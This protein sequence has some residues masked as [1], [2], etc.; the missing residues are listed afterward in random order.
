MSVINVVLK[1]T[2]PFST[3]CKSNVVS[4]ISL[5]RS[6]WLLIK[7]KLDRVS[8]PT[9]CFSCEITS[10]IATAP[11]LSTSAACLDAPFNVSSPT[12]C[13][14]ELITSLIAISAA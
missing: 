1:S 12:I 7:S 3:S 10:V 9:M 8:N 14:S 4:V 2:S 5:T 11:L 13:L 6:P